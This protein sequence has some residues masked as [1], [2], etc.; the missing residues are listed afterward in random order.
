MQNG[1]TVHMYAQTPEGE[2]RV[3]ILGDLR[4]PEQ[5]LGAIRNHIQAVYD[6]DKAEAT[7]SEKGESLPQDRTAEDLAGAFVQLGV[8]HVEKQTGALSYDPREYQFCWGEMNLSGRDPSDCR[9]GY[10]DSVD[11]YY[12]PTDTKPDGW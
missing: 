11:E 9:K 1:I 4:P 2:P 8:A 5:A 6:H 7:L 10:F 3:R 12:S